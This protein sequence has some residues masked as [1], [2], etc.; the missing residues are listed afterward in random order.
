MKTKWKTIQIK[1]L[2]FLKKEEVHICLR[3]WFASSLTPTWS[4]LELLRLPEMKKVNKK[5]EIN[6]APRLWG[7]RDLQKIHPKEGKTEVPGTDWWQAGIKLLSEHGSVLEIFLVNHSWAW[8]SHPRSWLEK[9]T[10]QS[11]LWRLKTGVRI[12][13][14][15]SLH[16]PSL[17]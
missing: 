9:Q 14:K 15:P 3:I 8:S 17:Q 1:L 16:K 2:H 6:L 4:T 7:G 13:W 11:T 5:E 12:S 10:S